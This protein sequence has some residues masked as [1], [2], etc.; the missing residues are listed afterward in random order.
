MITD[1]NSLRALGFRD[2]VNFDGTE[3]TLEH[4][5]PDGAAY[6][7]NYEN[8]TVRSLY[9]QLLNSEGPQYFMEDQAHKAVVAVLGNLKFKSPRNF[10]KVVDTTARIT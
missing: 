5:V 2:T 9:G 1:E 4:S 3:V 8:I 10:F 6:G 7:M